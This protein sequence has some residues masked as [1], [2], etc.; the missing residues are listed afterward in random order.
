MPSP[1]I[2]EFAKTL[3]EQVRD[4]A[5]SGCDV[6]LRP[7]ARSVTAERWHSAGVGRN[8]QT[9]VLIPDCVDA[10][11]FFLLNAIDQGVL[12]LQFKAANGK[13]VDLPSEGNGELA[14]WYLGEGGWRSRFSAERIA[15]Q[16]GRTT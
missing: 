6:N 9:E 1:E 11:L 5:V 4:Q 14:G 15:D 8:P 13:V 12:R 10:A 7:E 3:V 16:P 2:E